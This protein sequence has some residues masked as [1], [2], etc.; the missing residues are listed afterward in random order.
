MWQ[1]RP[2]QSYLVFGGKTLVVGD[3]DT[4]GFTGGLISR[5]YVKDTVGVDIKGHLNL[6]HTAGSRRD[7]GEFEFAEEVVVLCE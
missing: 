4:V 1:P 2:R 5:R 7:T 6:R 3:S